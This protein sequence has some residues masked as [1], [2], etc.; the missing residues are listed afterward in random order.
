MRDE[1]DVPAVRQGL[2]ELATT[3]GFPRADVE[4]MATALSEIA[5][6][7]VIHAAGGDIALSIIR[8]DAGRV[9]ILAVARDYGPGIPDTE[10]A[11]RDGFSTGKGLGLGLPSARRLTDE[12][13]I[14]SIAGQ[15][16]TVKLTKWRR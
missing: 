2:R 8:D 9:G 16:T 15:G 10:L 7:I 13:E 4:A 1:S 5:Y 6:N 12:F 3:V 11:M 14:Q